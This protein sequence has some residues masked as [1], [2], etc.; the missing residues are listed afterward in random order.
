VSSPR[1]VSDVKSGKLRAAVLAGYN[2]R[3]GATARDFQS[4][5]EQ[6]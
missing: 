6:E 2:T 5:V 4:L 1:N 3:N